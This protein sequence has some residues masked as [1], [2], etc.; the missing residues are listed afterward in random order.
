MLNLDTL[1]LNAIVSATGI[2]APDF[3]TIRSTLVSY[4][5]E[6]YGSDSYL[7]ADSK[8]G[9]MISIY[10]LAIHDANNSAI[11]VYNSFSPATGVGNGLSSNVKINGIKR[12]KE[13]NSTVDLLLTGSVGLVITNGAARDADG[14]R[15]DLPASVIIGLDGTATATAICS[16]PGAIV[17]L[18]NTVK[19][20]ATPT[21]G[22]LNVN[23]PTGATPG[24]PVELDA[25]LRVRQAVSVALPSRTVLDGILGAVA[26]IGGVERY[27][28]YENDTSITDGN[29]IPSHSISIVVD[30]GDATEIAQTIALKKGPGSGTYGTT[31]IPI[32]D[33]YGIVHPIN[34]FR[35]GTVRVYVKLEIK[36]LQGYT[37]SIGTAIKNSIA[38]YINEIE[39][40]EPV[41]I[42][43]L[44]LPAQLNGSIE[45]LTYD[46]TRLEIGISPV[47]LSES[48]IEIAFND[49]AACVPDNINLVVT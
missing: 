36:A 31:T 34:F 35:K 3:E 23:N 1:G 39:I 28:G 18:A 48:N 29:G 21:R 26:G 17:A 16:V 13:T 38:E 14:V 32:K 41:R 25:E 20:I 44:D 30:G 33:K 12:N 8:D 9:Q 11:A 7:D 5:Q 46:I 45:R 27:R 15:W 4:F 40:G 6:I 42:K 43:R 22:W 37:S 47:A 10:A 49:A 24:K 19:E 2:T